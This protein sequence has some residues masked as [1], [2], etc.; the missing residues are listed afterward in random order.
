[1]KLIAHGKTDKGLVRAENED[2]FCIE[3]DLGFLAVADGMGG[4]A[5]GE[6]ASKM[7]IDIVRN[8][9]KNE[10]NRSQAG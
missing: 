8:C 1:M 5:S 3:K 6:V 9:F 10:K 2:E 7:A 4:H